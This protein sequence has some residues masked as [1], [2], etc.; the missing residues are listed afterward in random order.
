MKAKVTK[1]NCKRVAQIAFKELQNRLS[2]Y[3]GYSEQKFAYE[4]NNMILD[5]FIIFKVA[6]TYTNNPYITRAAIMSINDFFES[7]KWKESM[8]YGAEVFVKNDKKSGKEIALP[9]VSISIKI[10]DDEQQG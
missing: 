2:C 7:S 10:E 6:P 4:V 8:F 3:G 5:K 1:K 9:C